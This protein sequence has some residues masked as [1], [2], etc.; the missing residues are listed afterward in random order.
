M[1]LSPNWE[2]VSDHVM[3]GVSSGG[4]RKEYLD[5]RDVV[6]LRGQ[7][8]LEN[9]GGFIQ[10]AF[11]LNPDGSDLDASDWRG[12]ELEICG[13]GEAYDVRLRTSDLSHSWQSFRASI[14]AN[15]QWQWVRVPFAAFTQHRTKVVFNPG[16]LRRVGVLA[17]GRVF[18]ADI[19][20][21]GVRF[22]K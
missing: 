12:L 19:T 15:A 17:I 10:V 9:N 22:Y 8:S 16:A 7:I 4:M 13:N 21:G 18:E 14:V 1:Q 11:D 6:R 2:Y 20:V 3:G 5:H